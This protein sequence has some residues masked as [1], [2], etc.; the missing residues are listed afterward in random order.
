MKRIRMVAVVLLA[1]TTIGVQARG[2]GTAETVAADLSSPLAAPGTGKGALGAGG[3]ARL[4]RCYPT[5]NPPER[6]AMEGETSGQSQKVCEAS[7]SRSR[8]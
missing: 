1:V 5:D 3:A 4:K 8:T 6:K 2:E 7:H